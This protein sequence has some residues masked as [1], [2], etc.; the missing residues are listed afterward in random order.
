MFP[1]HFQEGFDIFGA[2]PAPPSTKRQLRIST[3]KRMQ[4]R[5]QNAQVFISVVAILWK[6]P[7]KTCE[8]W[9]VDY[10][11]SELKNCRNKIRHKIHYLI[12]SL[13]PTIQYLFV[14]WC[15][16]YIALFFGV[17]KFKRLNKKSPIIIQK[18]INAVVMFTFTYI[19]LLK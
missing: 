9:F 8:L 11:R 10:K 13:V 4:W 7:N 2:H 6:F 3:A 5:N 19:Y 14:Y 15:F 16:K 1:R 17:K 12:W 18:K